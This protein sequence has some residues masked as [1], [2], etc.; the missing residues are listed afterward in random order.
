MT[1]GSDNHRSPATTLFGVRLEKRLTSIDDY[2]KIILE[3][4]EIGLYVPEGRFE[5]TGSPEIDERHKAYLLDASGR[6]VPAPK[7]WID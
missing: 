1:A 5:L 4:E 3:K 2:V 7:E 6:D